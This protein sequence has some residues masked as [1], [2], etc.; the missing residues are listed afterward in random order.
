MVAA[1]FVCASA[2]KWERARGEMPKSIFKFKCKDAFVGR[3]YTR[4][5]SEDSEK[6]TLK[7]AR[8]VQ[9]MRSM[10]YLHCISKLKIGVGIYPEAEM[11]IS[12][13][14]IYRKFDMH[15]L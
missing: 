10:R 12:L 3:D 2:T 15:L 1:E 4:D 11:F 9:F 7:I 5:F 6:E 8:N 14:C 13:F